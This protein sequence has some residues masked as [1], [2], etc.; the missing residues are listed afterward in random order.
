MNEAE[1]LKRLSQALNSKDPI[2]KAYKR[3]RA[4]LAAQ[5]RSNARSPVSARFAA[6]IVEFNAHAIM[7]EHRSTAKSGLEQAA[8]AR[9]SGGPVAGMEVLAVVL[10]YVAS[11]P[12]TPEPWRVSAYMQGLGDFLRYADEAQRSTSAAERERAAQALAWFF[13]RTDGRA[14]GLGNASDADLLYLLRRPRV[15]DLPDYTPRASSVA[16]EVKPAQRLS[17]CER[18]EMSRI[19]YADRAERSKPARTVQQLELFA[20]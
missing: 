13:E 6:H 8:R 20:A 3:E 11:I 2:A 19:D 15:L 16:G 7:R 10:Q 18:V 17:M 1:L 5:L 9:E 12:A 14:L 4:R